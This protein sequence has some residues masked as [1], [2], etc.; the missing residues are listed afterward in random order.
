[1][2]KGKAVIGTIPSGMR[3]MIV[4][5]ET[6]ILV[7]SGDVEALASAMK[8]LIDDDPLRESMGQAALERA[9]RFTSGV[10]MPKFEVLYDEVI[11]AFKHQQ[12]GGATG[13]SA[14]VDHF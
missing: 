4:N 6:G 9:K 11:Q 8:R 5:G 10:M 13:S 1:M 14:H 7:P 12:R 2:S 3:D